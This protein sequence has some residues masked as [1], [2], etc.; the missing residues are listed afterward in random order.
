MWSL[1]HVLLIS[2]GS[3][4]GGGISN[5]IAPLGQLAGSSPASAADRASASVRLHSNP[6]LP[7]CPAAYIAAAYMLLL[8]VQVGG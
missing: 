5:L 4:K 8:R 3:G 2:L 6:D 7:C 1:V